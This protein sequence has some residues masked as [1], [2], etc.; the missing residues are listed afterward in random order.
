MPKKEHKIAH[1]MSTTPV[2]FA[3]FD[4]LRINDSVMPRPLRE[5]QALLCSVVGPSDVIS[6][7]QSFED[8]HA[9]LGV[10]STYHRRLT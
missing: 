2:H 7:C 8:G 1:L 6:V 4:V 3:A 5:R 10:L 9:V